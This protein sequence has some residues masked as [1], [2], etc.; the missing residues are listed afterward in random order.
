MT[1]ARRLMPSEH[2][3]YENLFVFLWGKHNFRTLT[4]ARVIGQNNAYLYYKIY[5]ERESPFGRTVF[6]SIKIYDAN[7]IL[8]YQRII[9]ID[10]YNY[11]ITRQLF[12]PSPFLRYT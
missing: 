11:N 2:I 5:S 8:S 7:I 10:T 4:R 1:R 12:A 3:I 6:F 9:I